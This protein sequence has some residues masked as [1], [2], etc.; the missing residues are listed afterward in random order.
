MDDNTMHLVA[1]T[2]AGALL[3]AKH[4]PKP[5]TLGGIPPEAPDAVRLYEQVR[6][7]LERR[8]KPAP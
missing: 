7:E 3:Q 8:A 2:L 1:A 6:A 4:A 5:N